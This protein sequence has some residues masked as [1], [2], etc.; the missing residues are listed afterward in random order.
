[1]LANKHDL[2]SLPDYP[3]KGYQDPDTGIQYPYSILKALSPTE[4]EAIG[5]Y[6]VIDSGYIAHDPQTQQVVKDPLVYTGSSIVQN[7]TVV[8]YD[9]YAGWD[10]EQLRNVRYADNAKVAQGHIEDAQKNPY[11]GA[12]LDDRKEQKENNKR[13]NRAKKN[14]KMT[15]R[16]D[17]LT[18]HIDDIFDVQDNADDAVENMNRS[19]LE[20]FD[21]SSVTYPTWEPPA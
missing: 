10:T 20:T 6:E 18:D 15:D 14:N 11:V 16:D 17:A 4:A 19:E 3:Q 9:P 1:M 12:V 8:P 13:N 5:W 2:I 7:Y 21:A